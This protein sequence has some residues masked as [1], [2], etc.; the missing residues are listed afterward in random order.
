MLTI[1]L[2]GGTL[3]LAP[4]AV[5]AAPPEPT[6]P[7]FPRYLLDRVDDLFRGESSHSVSSMQVK[8][9]H[10]ERSM[11]L[12]GWSLGQDYSLIRILEPKKERG[13]ATLKAD[14]DLFTYL[15]KTGRTIKISGASM[16]GSWMG[17]HF[18]NDDLIKDSRLA[19]DFEYRL[20]DGPT[21]EGER[22]WAVILIPKPDAIVVWGRIDVMVRKSDLMPAGQLFYDEDLKPVRKLEFSDYR[23]IGGRNV[24]QRMR[25]SP[26]DEPGEFT[27]IRYESIEF[28]VAL[29]P[30]FFTVQQLKA[31]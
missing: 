2:V 28:G 1:A 29:S 9:K 31:I 16:G 18:T 4:G 13:T 26:L 5:A 10:W 24:A 30:A 19:D 20:E 11:K 17:S 8:T 22:T 12:E 6:D 21:I 23:E 27:E 3:A 25:M 7:E 14:G 15:S